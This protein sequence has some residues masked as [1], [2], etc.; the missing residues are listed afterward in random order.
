VQRIVEAYDAH[1][2]SLAPELRPASG[3]QG[4]RRA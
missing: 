2:S 4:R 1:A 3:Q